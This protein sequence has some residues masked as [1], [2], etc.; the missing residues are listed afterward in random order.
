MTMTAHEV[1]LGLYNDSIRRD[2]AKLADGVRGILGAR[3]T[4]YIGS[5][6]QT[7]AVREWAEG[8]RRPSA[9]VVE[10]L[11]LAYL[12]A[13]MIE[14]REGRGIAQAWFQGMNPQLNDVSPARVIRES[15]PADVGAEVIAA[16]RAFL[17]E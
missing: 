17:A 12:T 15:D 2:P 8:V 10:R 13:S 11:R 4:A 9:I 5:V 14:Q 6:Q 1:E 3:L 16:T 7:R